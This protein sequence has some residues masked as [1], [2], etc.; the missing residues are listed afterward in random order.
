MS[1]P[2]SMDDIQ[3]EIGAWA[4]SKGWWD[5]DKL[6]AAPKIAGRNSLEICALIASEVSEAVEEARL[7]RMATTYVVDKNGVMKPEGFYSE[8][9]DVV[10][11]IMDTFAQAGISLHDEILT[12]MVYNREREHRHGGKL[13]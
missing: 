2:K 11:R 9:A 7:G 1:Y 13:A 8:L 4:E 10:I 6:D 3:D 12:K 5:A